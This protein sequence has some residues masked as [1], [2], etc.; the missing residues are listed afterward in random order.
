[1]VLSWQF[2]ATAA[3]ALSPFAAGAE[4]QSLQGYNATSEIEAGILLHCKHKEGYLCFDRCFEGGQGSCAAYFESKVVPPKTII[5]TVISLVTDTATVTKTSTTTETSTVTKTLTVQSIV[6]TTD[7]VTA[8]FTAT[9]TATAT[10]TVRQTTRLT[11]TATTTSLSTVV[12]TFPPMTVT[13]TLSGSTV[14]STISASTMTRIETVEII[15]TITLAPETIILTTTTPSPVSVCPAPTA[16]ALVARRSSNPRLKWGCEPGYICSP[17]KPEGCNVWSSCPPK[18]YVCE[19]QYCRPAPPLQIGPETSSNETGWVPPNPFYFNLDPTKFGLTGSIFEK[20]E[21]IQVVEGQTTTVTTGDWTP[22]ASVAQPT[23]APGSP[24]LHMYK[25]KKREDNLIG[26]RRILSWKDLRNAVKRAKRLYRRQNGA[27]L[28]PR[29]AVCYRPCHDAFLEAQ[30]IGFRPR[31]CIEGSS[32]Q[33]NVNGCFGC[34]D[35]WRNETQ[36][37]SVREYVGDQFEEYLAYCDVNDGTTPPSGPQSIVS[38]EPGLTSASQGGAV[39][40][41]APIPITSTSV[42]TSDSASDSSSVSSSNLTSDSASDSASASTSTS[43]TTTPPT[44]GPGPTSTGSSLPRTTATPR[45]TPSVPVVPT[46]QSPPTVT[47]AGAVLLKGS[48]GTALLLT[49]L[50]VI[51]GQI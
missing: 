15:Q 39:T 25:P 50:A 40:S 46:T 21:V 35:V 34:L 31:L 51:V 28:P 4:G 49:L 45:T 17:P 47:T 6:L 27:N 16:A 11:T 33:D 7:T 18:D 22:H 14:F 8:S 41:G 1:M 9:E 23:A 12:T 37:G 2:W 29:M 20:Y 43:A 24:A 38:T 5:S 13:M 32:Y 36:T 10:E 19:P 42:S 3:L 48:P 30:D 44:T 26:P